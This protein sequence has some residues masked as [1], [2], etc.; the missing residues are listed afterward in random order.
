MTNKISGPAAIEAAYREA[1]AATKKQNV[2]ESQRAMVAFMAVQDHAADDTETLY[3]LLRLSR[4]IKE[5]RMNQE[6]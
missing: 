4:L 5:Q 1:L 3:A 6:A 2:P